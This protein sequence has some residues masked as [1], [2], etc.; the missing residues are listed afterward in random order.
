[1]ALVL[2]FLLRNWQLV[3]G[4]IALA[5]VYFW[6]QGK[7]SDAYKSG[8]EEGRAN[9]TAA[10][11]AEYNDKKNIIDKD[12]KELESIKKET[13]I[14]FIPVEKLVYEFI[15][16]PPSKETCGAY[17]DLDKPFPDDFIRLWNAVID[18]STDEIS[19]IPRKPTRIVSREIP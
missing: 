12:A 6:Y 15:N 3:V 1:M 16:Q 4:A 17:V 14:K 19:E 9:L 7:L 13:E 2:G 18:G 11:L 10:Y 8:W 5:A